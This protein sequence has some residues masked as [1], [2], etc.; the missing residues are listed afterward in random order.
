MKKLKINQK[1][2]N[3]VNTLAI[4]LDFAKNLKKKSYND[5]K[6]KNFKIFQKEKIKQN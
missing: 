4:A 1:K 6:K 5:I 3:L 2:R